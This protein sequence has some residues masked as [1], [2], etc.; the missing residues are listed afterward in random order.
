M[1][2][3]RLID[4]VKEQDS[5]HLDTVKQRRQAPLMADDDEPAEGRHRLL[6]AAGA[7]LAEAQ[8]GPS[9]VSLRA[10]ARRAG[11]S[12]NAATHHF[13]DRAGLL[14]ALAVEGFRQLTAAL[15]AA[16]TEADARGQDVLLALGTAYLDFGLAQPNLVELMFR[17]DLV[18]SADPA[19]Q[20]AQTGAFGV[21]EDAAAQMPGR[22]PGLSATDFALVAWSFVHGVLG[23]ARHGALDREAGPEPERGTPVAYQVLRSFGALLGRPN[24]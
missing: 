4:T 8:A 13:G 23:L 24:T 5:S 10:I 12:H 20:T 22:P 17:P 1:R 16:W 19:L 21:L 3:S 15:Q 6:A 18:R 11:L 2:D 7:E 14:T 9:Q